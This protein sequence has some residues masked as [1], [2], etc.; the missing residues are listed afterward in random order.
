MLYK[1]KQTNGV[2]DSLETMPFQ[3]V[4]LEKNLENL[5]ADSLLD[6]LFEG[7]ELMPILQERSQQEEADIY[8]LNEKGELIL[9]ELK[10]GGAGADAVHQLLRY[11]EK[12]AHW[13]YE[14][15]QE[16]LITYSKGKSADLQEEHRIN[17]D[18]EHPL[19]KSA[20]N[21]QQRMI[22]I[23]SAANEDLIHNVEYWKS[24]G[25]LIDFIPY[26]VYAMKNGEAK[27]H[28]FEFFSIPFDRHSNPAHVK[29]V[30]FD[31]CLSHIPDSIWYMCQN[32]RGAA[33][34][35]QSHVVNYLNKNDIVFLYHKW[36]GIVAA[37]KVIS[38]VKA[39][40]REDANYR[41]LEWLT[42]KPLKVGGEPKAMSP[43][44]IKDILKHDF[45]WARTIKTPYLSKDESDK[46]LEALINQIGP[47]L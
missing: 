7:N 14:R 12:A 45:F 2:F 16:M 38:G 35:D 30:L 47:K 11:C 32:N 46:L 3:S 28:Y 20:F 42:A 43:G 6:V 22:V 31:T 40:T 39:D 15:L 19:E 34:G 25:L 26:R 18:L 21:R 5:L 41:D 1:L 37:G 8:A 33:F 13:K 17:F 24:K 44:K 9:F 23:G 10:R 36:A 29:G 4:P 27:E